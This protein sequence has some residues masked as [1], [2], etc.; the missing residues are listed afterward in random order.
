MF[1]TINWL[2]SV[3][4]PYDHKSINTDI[5]LESPQSRPHWLLLLYSFQ[6]RSALRATPARH[7]HCFRHGQPC[8]FND[9]IDY[10]V[11]ECDCQ[12]RVLVHRSAASC[13]CSRRLFSW[14]RMLA[15]ERFHRQGTVYCAH[16]SVRPSVRPYVCTLSC[17]R[18]CDDTHRTPAASVS[19]SMTSQIMTYYKVPAQR[20]L[21]RIF[22]KWS[23]DSSQEYSL[24]SSSSLYNRPIWESTRKENSICAT[25]I[26]F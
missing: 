12:Q 8:G 2:R 13:L 1:W 26:A 23:A 22:T 5:I 21:R 10:H 4:R 18:A 20:L 3:W 25:V 19:D 7:R 17:F 16:P 24:I 6:F 11:S 9:S 15:S 14:A